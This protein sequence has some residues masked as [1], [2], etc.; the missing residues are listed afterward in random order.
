MLL[1]L[2]EAKDG[3]GGLDVMTN[4]LIPRQIS[5]I[6]KWI[7]MGLGDEDEDEDDGPPQ[8]KLVFRR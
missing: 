5:E 7:N 2:K 3:E 1:I 6:E 4:V 8:K